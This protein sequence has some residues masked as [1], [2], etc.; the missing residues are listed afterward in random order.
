MKWLV[1]K[2]DIFNL[3]LDRIPDLEYLL[4]SLKVIPLGAG[5]KYFMTYFFDSDQLIDSRIDNEVAWKRC[6]FTD[7][8]YLMI[9]FEFE[10][11][12]LFKQ[13]GYFRIFIFRCFD[14]ILLS[15][16]IFPCVSGFNRYSRSLL[17]FIELCNDQLPCFR[18]KE[19]IVMDFNSESFVRTNDTADCQLFCSNFFE[20]NRSFF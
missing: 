9:L 20:L 2:N 7:I 8:Y 15:W 11:C 4:K 17:D 3:S 14:V 16:F 10:M 19:G 12:E 6:E 1:N 18:V 13:F 5:I